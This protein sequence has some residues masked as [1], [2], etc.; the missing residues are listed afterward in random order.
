M[1]N[2]PTLTIAPNYPLSEDREDAT[3]RS[4]MEGGYEY[5]RPKYT[6]GR[7]KF[8]ITYTNMQ[9]TDKDTL[10]AFVDTVKGGAD[11]FIWTHPKTSTN[12]TA[13]FD[14]PPKFEYVEYNFWNV[15]FQLNQV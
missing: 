6:R 4:G 2:Y 9:N 5:T 12:Y 11:S 8:G 10:E 1:A 7:K 3:Y 15:S 13:Q 14:K